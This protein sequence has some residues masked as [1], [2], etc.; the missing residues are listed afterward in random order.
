[1]IKNEGKQI[2]IRDWLPADRE[3]WIFWTSPGKDWQKFDGPYYPR[4]TAEEIVARVN[5][6]YKKLNAGMLPVPRTSLAI[7]DRQTGKL[8]GQVGWYWESQE[9]NWLCAG[10]AIFNSDFWGRGLGYEA[11]GLW[12]DYLFQAMPKIVRVDLRTWSGNMGMMKL[13]EKL[14]Y[15]KEACFRKARIVNGKYYDSIG[16]GVLREEWEAWHLDG[17]AKDLVSNGKIGKS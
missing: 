17:F 13:A 3:D 12:T 10:I 11:F 5:G 7:A 1:M 16:Y 2:I 4:S 14:G 8:I 9:T 6:Y 15:I